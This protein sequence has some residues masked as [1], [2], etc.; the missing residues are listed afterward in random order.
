[1]AEKFDRRHRRRR[2]FKPDERKAILKRYHEMTA[3]GKTTKEAALEVDISYNT[4]LA[5]KKKTDKG[6]K[7]VQ[8]AK[9]DEARLPVSRGDIVMVTPG[10]ARV[11]GLTVDDL[12]VVLREIR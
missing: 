12:I 2:I 7:K 8:A 3:S 6:G 11:E 1:M 10:G 4:L 9:S 5:W